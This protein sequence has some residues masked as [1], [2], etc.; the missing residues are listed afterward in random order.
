MKKINK[1]IFIQQ[2]I[3]FILH[4]KKLIKLKIKN[5][6]NILDKLMINNKYCYNNDIINNFTYSNNNSEITNILEIIKNKNHTLLLI[7]KIK[8]KCINIIKTIG[9]YNIHELI[10]F[11]DNINIHTFFNENKHLNLIN[12]FFK[13]T[14]YYTLNKDKS[15]NKNVVI[16]D[17]KISDKYNFNINDINNVKTYLIKPISKKNITFI[18]NIYGA[19]IYL[20]LNQNIIVLTGYFINDYLNIINHDQIIKKKNI[21]IKEHLN[22][23]QINDTFKKNYILQIS[24]RDLIVLETNEIINK[25]LNDFKVVNIYKNETISFIVKDFLSKDLFNQRNILVLL[26]LMKDNKN[27]QNTAYLLYELIANDSYLL[28]AQPNSNLIYD[29]LH[30]SIQKEFKGS[31]KTFNDRI[32]KSFS[33]NDIDYE[34]RI[35]LLNCDQKVKDKA[36]DKLKEILNKSSDNSSKAQTYLDSLLKIPFNIYKKEEIF[37]SFDMIKNKINILIHKL[38][39]SQ[40]NDYLTKDLLYFDIENIINVLEN[41][42]FVSF[43]I[44]P[45]HLYKKLI[46]CFVYKH[47]IKQIDTLLNINLKN[48]NK[49]T[50]ESF[51]LKNK[52]KKI[53]NIIIKNL[54]FSNK[55]SSKSCLSEIDNIINSWDNYK[56]ERINYIKDVDKILSDAIYSQNDAK[57]E[58]KRIL[59]QWMNGKMTGYCLGFEGPPGVGKT[60]LAKKGIANCLKDSN[61]KSRPFSFIAL[62]G[63]SNGSVLEGHNYTYVGSNYGKIVD[64]L[65]ETQ[66]MN[67]I[68]YIDELDKVSNTENGREIIGI[69][70]HLTDFSQNDIFN[71]KYFSGINLDLSKAVFIFSYNDYSKI[72][73]IL[74]DRI[75]RIKF[76]YLENPEKIFIMDNYIVPNLLSNVGQSKDTINIDKDIIKHIIETYTCEGGVRKLSERTFEIIR[77]INLDLINDFNSFKK[78][79]KVS[80]KYVDSLFKTKLKMDNK[81][82]DNINKVGYVNGLYATSIGT[83]GI[84]VIQCSKKYSDTKF[85]ITITGQQGDVMK[86]SIQ[87][88]QTLAWNIIPNTIKQKILKEWKTN[89]PFGLH[90]HCPDTATPKD[91]PSAGAA[92]TLCIISLLCNLKVKNNIALTGEIDVKGCITKIGGLELKFSGAKKANIETVLIPEDNIND[93]EYIKKHK[94]Y[95]LENLNVIIVNNI[96][97]VLSIC[98]INPNNIEFNLE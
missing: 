91:G 88:S 42:L 12:K 9:F 63:S 72:D 5:I 81:I 97:E 62:G 8:T 29:S 40:L 4:I 60:T 74:A 26:L 2:R 20:K 96:L 77:Q 11:T 28:K 44:L 18:E 80:K 14:S 85:S 57:L 79:I 27:L 45:N 95:I 37:L 92:I 38:N 21:E 83:G 23:L 94:P 25:L 67:P 65:I 15:T 64:I 69:L 7:E 54:N 89:S 17:N 61:G 31:I 66:C 49:K 87:C 47:K 43:N 16:Y 22:Y 53:T 41:I 6:Y 34:K 33:V 35:N 50:Y 82:I 13:P 30:W 84:T 48:K 19:I 56:L 70:T 75:H 52:K 24:T 10:S 32:S 1:I 46:K 98:L 93:Y 71:D 58:I 73:P 3:K 90:V 86:E 76:N 36:F 59:A 55:I 78:H 51:L 68:I 39:I